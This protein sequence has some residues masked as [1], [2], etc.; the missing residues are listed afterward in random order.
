MGLYHK[1]VFMPPISLP[2]GK[3]NLRYYQH[4]V[5]VANRRHIPLLGVLDT[6]NAEVVEVKTKGAIPEKVVFRIPFDNGDH[7]CL[8]VETTRDTWWVRTLWKNRAD[9]NHETLD[10]SKYDR[11]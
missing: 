6:K 11:E 10:T 8:A 1:D 9:D 5:E 3:F 4:A 7:L 2:Q